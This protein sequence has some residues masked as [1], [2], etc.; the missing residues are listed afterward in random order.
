VEAEGVFV[1]VALAQDS[2]NEET[3]RVAIKAL[4]I[5]CVA[6][7]MEDQAVTGGAALGLAVGVN[8]INT[9][10]MLDRVMYA[11]CQLTTHEVHHRQLVNNGVLDVIVNLSMPQDLSISE[12]FQFNC[13]T[14]LRNLSISEGF[15]HDQVFSCPGAIPT[16]LKFSSSEQPRT[17]ANIAV[18]LHNLAKDDDKAQRSIVK[19]GGISKLIELSESETGDIR[20]VC[21][22]TLQMLSKYSQLDGGNFDTSRFIGSVVTMLKADG[23]QVTNIVTKVTKDVKV[24]E[25]PYLKGQSTYFEGMVGLDETIWFPH[26]EPVWSYFSVENEGNEG[27]GQSRIAPKDGK[28]EPIKPHSLEH[29][30]GDLIT[31]NFSRIE[32]PLTKRDVAP[33]VVEEDSV[34]NSRRS[35]QTS[36]SF[37]DIRPNSSGI[38][39]NNSDSRSSSRG[40]TGKIGTTSVELPPIP[41]PDASK[42]F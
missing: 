2:S 3:I 8:Y 26:S 36:V 27:L 29:N 33:L 7:G 21:A 28:M 22:I 17:R 14:A 18:F 5:V 35:S 13:S 9:V 41:P 11:I 42:F 34:S 40:L 4:A 23:A 37:A 30:D 1:L 32:L 19:R 12:N 20:V 38:K 25:A 16:I 15:V 24:G 6:E 31:G 39:S 10:V